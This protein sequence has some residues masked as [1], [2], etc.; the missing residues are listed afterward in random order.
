MPH[1]HLQRSALVNLRHYRVT[2]TTAYQPHFGISGHLYEMIEY[3]MHFRYDKNIDACILISDGTTRDM[4]F[5]AIDSKYD[6]TQDELQQFKDHT[7]FEFKPF[8]IYADTLLITNGSM[9]F[10]GADLFAR[11]KLVFRCSNL[12]PGLDRD[13]ITLLQDPR[14]YDDMSNSIPY[15]KRMMFSKYKQLEPKHPNVGMFYAKSNSKVMHQDEFDYLVDKHKERFDSFI[16]LT[17]Q[18]TYVPEGV[19]LRLVPVADLGDSFSTYIYTHKESTVLVDCSPRFHAECK[20]YGKE[21]IIEAPEV[22]KGLAARLYDIE[23]N[24]VWLREDDEISSKI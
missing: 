8:V 5:S 13:D 4:F 6:L 20:H 1:L 18:E 3:F 17:D 23:H 16:L 21:L 15:K 10:E 11:K 22:D 7:Y 9:R 24:D 19:E 14:I 2:L 12:E